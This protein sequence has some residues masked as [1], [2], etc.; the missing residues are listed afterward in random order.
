MRGILEMQS[1]CLEHQQL[2]PECA[3]MEYIWTNRLFLI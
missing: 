3:V 1:L 2:T